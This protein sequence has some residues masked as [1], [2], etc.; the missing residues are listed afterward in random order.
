[1]GTSR[2]RVLRHGAWTIDFP[3]ANGVSMGT[4]RSRIGIRSVQ[5]EPPL[6]PAPDG[7]L[8]ASFGDVS[9]LSAIRRTGA[10]CQHLA[11]NSEG[12]S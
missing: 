6:T 12:P 5:L 10:A 4:S 2:P 3:V 8:N 9:Q 7:T 1:M 11:G